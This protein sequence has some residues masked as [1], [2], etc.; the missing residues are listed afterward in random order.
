L[1]PFQGAIQSHVLWGWILYAWKGEDMTCLRRAPL[2]IPG[3][4]SRKIDKG[5]TL[6]ADSIILD[7]EDGVAYSRKAEARQIVAQALQ[8]N[9][10][11]RSERLVRINSFDSDLGEEDLRETLAGRPDGFVLPKVETA[12][13]IQHASEKI[14]EYE[15]SHGIQEGHTRLL[16]SIETA[17]GVINVREIASADSR[18]DALMFGA[19]DLASDLGAIRTRSG[20][21]VFY[22]KSAVVT[23]ASAY[24]L[25]AIDSPSINLDDHE[26]LIAEARQAA[27]LGYS[28]KMA[29]H[30]AQLEALHTIF[31]PSPEAVAAAQRLL[32]AYEAHRASGKG[33]FILDGKLVELPMAR[34]A[35]RIVIKMRA[36]NNVPA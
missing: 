12:L 11:G 13:T 8:A 4:S 20:W 33:V 5:L 35:Q 29:I 23:A 36:I 28:G 1:A 25:Q 15:R 34:A 17:L 21:E 22:A 26:S 18:L 19:E 14:G 24:E 32:D 2:F 6:N 7:L 27:E 16:A 3:D 30:P 31:T 10:F 9:D